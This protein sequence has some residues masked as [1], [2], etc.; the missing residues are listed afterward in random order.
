M[1]TKYSAIIRRKKHSTLTF[2]LFPFIKETIFF[3]EQLLGS[4]TAHNIGHGIEIIC[5]TNRC[6]SS[7][8]KQKEY[9]SVQKTGAKTRSVMK[10]GSTSLKIS[11]DFVFLVAVT[12]RQF[13]HVAWFFFNF[14]LG[15]AAISLFIVRIR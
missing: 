13:A 9:D 12:I 8:N 3:G 11:E 6:L 5:Q 4:V 10:K 1:P 7:R 14:P 2:Q 15:F